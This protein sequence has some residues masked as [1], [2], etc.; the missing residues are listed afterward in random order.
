MAISYSFGAHPDA[1]SRTAFQDLRLPKSGHL[2]PLPGNRIA[3]GTIE[4]ANGFMLRN[5]VIGYRIAMA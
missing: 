4:A 5:T 1:G 2:S 3:C